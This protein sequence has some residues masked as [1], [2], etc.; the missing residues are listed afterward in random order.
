MIYAKVAAY[1]CP[2]TAG[3]LRASVGDD[4]IRDAV[5]ADDMLEE[6]SI[7]SFWK[8]FASATVYQL[9]RPMAPSLIMALQN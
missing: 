1:P 2:E 8:H 4:V 3:E 9:T 7:K 6:E 5:L